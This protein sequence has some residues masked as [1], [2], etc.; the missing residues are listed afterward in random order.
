MQKKSFCIRYLRLFTSDPYNNTLFSKGGGGDILR[1]RYGLLM[2]MYDVGQGRIFF[3]ILRIF[4]R[5]F[6]DF[7]S[8]YSYNMI[9]FP[10]LFFNLDFLPKII[11]PLPLLIPF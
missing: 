8:N 1:P 6:A 2:A 4:T 10:N 5:Q 3:L 7:R 11:C 9:F